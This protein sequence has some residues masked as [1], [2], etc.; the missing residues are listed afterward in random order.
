MTNPRLAKSGR[1]A[2]SFADLCL[3]LLGFFVLLHAT[4]EKDR[5]RAL[6]S[7][8]AELGAGESA[9]SAEAEPLR[10]PADSLF[11]AREAMLT[12]KGRE[13]IAAFANE[14]RAKGRSLQISSTGIAEQSGRFDAWD[15]AS[16]RLGAVARALVQADVPAEDIALLGAETQDRS[17]GD[18]MIL[19]RMMPKPPPTD[20]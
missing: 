17:G 4:Q 13:V 18:H 19:I 11:V 12:P 5:G 2:L 1:W 20:R 6:A 7:I 10:L 3:L 8:G 15:L 9:A 14:A 16:A